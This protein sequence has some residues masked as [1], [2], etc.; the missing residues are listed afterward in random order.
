[1]KPIYFRPLKKGPHFTPFKNDRFGAHLVSK[2]GNTAKKN[3][4]RSLAP[5]PKTKGRAPKSEITL[6]ILQPSLF[7]G[8]HGPPKPTF[9]EVFMVNNL[10]IFHGFGGSWYVKFQGTKGFCSSSFFTATWLPNTF[11]HRAIS[12]LGRWSISFWGNLGLFSKAMLALGRGN[13]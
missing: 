11:F 7:S 9:L 6:P 8:Y 5:R 10:F 4:S 13:H 1:M 3:A 2:F 12:M